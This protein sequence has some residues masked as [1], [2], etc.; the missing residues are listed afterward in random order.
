MPSIQRER[1]KDFWSRI[2]REGRNEKVEKLHAELLASGMTQR[3][4]Q[5][6]LVERFQSLDG[7]RTRAWDTPDSW[8]C[9]RK[10]W[11]KPGPDSQEQ[12]EQDLVWVYRNR[13]KPF[14]EAPT[15]GA[16]ML[17]EVAQKS[18]ERFLRT[19]QLTLPAIT[20][21]QE[22]ILEDNRQRLA[23]MRMERWRAIEQERARRYRE[24][25]EIRKAEE[26]RQADVAKKEQ[27]RLEAVRR[28]HARQEAARKVQERIDLEQ[29]RSPVKQR[30]VSAIP[31][32]AE[33]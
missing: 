18:P 26:A 31:D 22:E 30:L 21:R 33:F 1:K 29:K 2:G 20:E 32:R 3:E 27:E 12:F 17:L 8:E 16:R 14:E 19:C 24:K 11:K 25:Q 15:Q 7:S 28:E 10:D 4:A 6:E 23:A 13:D 9:G 5:A